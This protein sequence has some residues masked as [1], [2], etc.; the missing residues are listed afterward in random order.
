[1]HKRFILSTYRNVAPSCQVEFDKQSMGVFVKFIA[2]I[3]KA[4]LYQLCY[5]GCRYDKTCTRFS[6][7]L[8]IT[9]QLLSSYCSIVQAF[10]RPQ[11][12]TAY[13]LNISTPHESH[14]ISECYPQCK[15]A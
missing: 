14:C 15:Q 6:L 2:D 1:M 9:N 11:T 10:K 4:S 12:F 5:G 8:E 3:T 7:L 13:K